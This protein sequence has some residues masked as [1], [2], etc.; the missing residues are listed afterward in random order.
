[1][2]MTATLMASA[3]FLAAVEISTANFRLI[4]TH[5][6]TVRLHTSLLIVRA[7]RQETARSCQVHLL[8]RKIVFQLSV[9]TEDCFVG[10][11]MVVIYFGPL[12]GAL[13]TLVSKEFGY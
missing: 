11:A 3:F 12:E 6:G 5:K 8:W 4:L 13:L 7:V 1:M 10:C 2:V 9:V